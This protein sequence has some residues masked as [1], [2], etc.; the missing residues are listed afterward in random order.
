MR[1]GLA[2]VI[3]ASCVLSGQE[4]LS[5]Q[6]FGQADTSGVAERAIGVHGSLPAKNSKNYL[7]D[8]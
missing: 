4:E 7:V 8:F 2:I 6:G 3:H 1:M 5:R